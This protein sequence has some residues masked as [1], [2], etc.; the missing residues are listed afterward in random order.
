[1]ITRNNLLKEYPRISQSALPK[2]LQRAEFDFIDENFDLIDDDEDIEKYIDT[3][4]EKLNEAVEKTN[5]IVTTNWHT[6]QKIGHL[7]D[8]TV[9]IRYKF[10]YQKKLSKYYHPELT[11]LS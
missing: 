2:A 1:M 5:T 10:R 6:F 9:V 4:I 3:F 8:R 11:L 7:H